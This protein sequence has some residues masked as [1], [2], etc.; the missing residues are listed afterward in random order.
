MTTRKK[1]E[2][3]AKKAEEIGAFRPATK[4]HDRHAHAHR[5]RERSPEYCLSA[6]DLIQNSVAFLTQV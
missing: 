6:L 3:K 1:P 2:V 4:S 5:E